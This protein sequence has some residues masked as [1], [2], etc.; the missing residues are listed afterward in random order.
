[1]ADFCVLPLDHL[2]DGTLNDTGFVFFKL[3]CPDLIQ[4]FVTLMLPPTIGHRDHSQPQTIFPL[5]EI[6]ARAPI[7]PVAFVENCNV[8]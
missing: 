1:M 6:P 3:D 4:S 2:V 8:L 5:P 7:P